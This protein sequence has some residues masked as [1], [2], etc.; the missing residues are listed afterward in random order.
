MQTVYL[1]VGV[2]GFAL[3]VWAARV[4]PD[5]ARAMPGTATRRVAAG[6]YRFMRHPMYVGT[7]LWIVG[8]AGCGGGFGSAFAVGILAELLFRDWIHRER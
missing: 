1:G 8:M 2:V 3:T 5:G 7:W 4:N 6:P